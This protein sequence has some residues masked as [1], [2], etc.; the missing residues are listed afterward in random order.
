VRS[1]RERLAVDDERRWGDEHPV[2]ASGQDFDAQSPFFV[3]LEVAA[4]G[5]EEHRRLVDRFVAQFL[6]DPTAA[7]VAAREA[8]VRAEDADEVVRSAVR[9]FVLGLAAGSPTR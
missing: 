3:G 4:I 1:L 6:A 9:A 8:D 2:G 5:K 7:A